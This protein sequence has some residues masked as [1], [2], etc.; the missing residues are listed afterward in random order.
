MG[1]GAMPGGPTGEDLDFWLAPQNGEL[2]KIE[3][4]LYNFLCTEYGV[5]INSVE[6]EPI[7]HSYMTAFNPAPCSEALAGMVW[8]YINTLNGVNLLPQ[9]ADVWFP[10]ETYTKC[11]GD[12]LAS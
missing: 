5:T 7:Y 11:S 1:T 3:Y 2:T 10:W 12:W 6:V 9:L 4:E 8:A